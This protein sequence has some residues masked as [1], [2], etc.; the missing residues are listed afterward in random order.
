MPI[1]T[2]PKL[3]PAGFAARD[4]D[5]KPEPT[6]VTVA[7]GAVPENATLPLLLPMAWGAKVAV[8]PAVCP[9]AKFNGRV[10]PLTV[11]VAPVTVAC[12][13]VNAV[14]PVLLRLPV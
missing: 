4:P 11:N 9:G 12:D 5:A 8:N 13:T 10:S 7:V 2:L 6:S 1:C 14:P 3:T